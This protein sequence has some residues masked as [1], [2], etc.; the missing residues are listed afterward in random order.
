MT[1]IS[2]DFVRQIVDNEIWAEVNAFR[3]TD[4][5]E[6]STNSGATLIGR[7]AVEH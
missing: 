7:P 5:S 6:F 2:E 1:G 4:M 3:K